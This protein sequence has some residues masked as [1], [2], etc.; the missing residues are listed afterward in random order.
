MREKAIMHNI[1]NKFYDCKKN[2]LI[3][4][5][6]SPASYNWLHNLKNLNLS[7]ETPGHA[8]HNICFSVKQGQKCDT[9]WMTVSEGYETEVYLN[10][11]KWVNIN[12]ILMCR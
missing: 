5:L 1:Q 2:Q 11:V 6:D 12:N 3:I 10:I 4:T 9:F 7:V 8:P